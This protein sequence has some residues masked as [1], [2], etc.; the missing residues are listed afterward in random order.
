MTLLVTISLL[1]IKCYTEGLLLIN[2]DYKHNDMKWNSID[3]H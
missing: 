2:N 1:V 3:K